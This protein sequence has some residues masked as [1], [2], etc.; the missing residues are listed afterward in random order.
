[1]ELGFTVDSTLHFFA[2]C[3]E[4]NVMIHVL[5]TC[6][7]ENIGLGQCFEMANHIISKISDPY[8]L[9]LYEPSLCQQIIKVYLL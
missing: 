6:L 9:Q 4:P 1:M 3:I 8:I 5:I 7:E 2:N